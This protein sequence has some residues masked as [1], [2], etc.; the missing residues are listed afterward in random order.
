MRPI[1]AALPLMI[2]FCV[3]SRA[4]RV[5]GIVKTCCTSSSFSNSMGAILYMETRRYLYTRTNIRSLV[6][7]G[8]VRKAS[9]H[10]LDY[11]QHLR[12]VEGSLSSFDS[13][14]PA[15]PISALRIQSFL[16]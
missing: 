11:P 5:M 13:V 1:V 10:E 8:S 6:L 16:A 7:L 9:R 4:S 3:S 14:A 15:R 12:E 2:S